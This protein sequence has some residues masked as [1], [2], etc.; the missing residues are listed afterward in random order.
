MTMINGDWVMARVAELAKLS[1]EEG[2]LTR[3]FLSPAHQRGCAQVGDWM[4]AAGMHV[5]QDAIAN[6]IGRYEGHGP[7]AP[8]L[9]IG[10]HIDTVRDAGW[11][12]G[13]LGVILGIAAVRRLHETG[14]H[15]P[16]AIEVIAFGDEENLRFPTSL[17]GSC[18]LAGKLTP[19]ELDAKDVS[20][21]S[22][23]EELMRWGLDP[24]SLADAARPKTD[25]LA[26][27]EVHIEQGPVLDR[28]DLPL[29]IVTAINGATRWRVTLTGMAGHAGTVPMT[30]RQ[31]ALAGFAEI[32]LAVEALG[33]SVPGLV[34]TVGQV[35]ARPGAANVIAGQVLFTIDTRHS[36]DDIRRT[37]LDQLDGLLKDIASRRQLILAVERYYD[38][39][40]APCDRHLQKAWA[41]SLIR[42]GITVHHLASGAG[43]DAMAL[44]G[45][46]PMAMLFVRCDKGISHN[47][48]E[49]ILAA[50]ADLALS[51]LCDFISHFDLAELDRD[52]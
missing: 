31:D 12:D 2:R 4:R 15:F 10:S 34:A 17:L 32:T 9:I 50:D 45:H 20:G 24:N 49:S 5:R 3:L 21:I 14:T 33:N 8:A 40:A 18:A 27:I 6:V 11:Y 16:F 30:M 39:P 52:S 25:A 36:D 42:L 51:V 41:D 37:A 19:G 46:W 22:V 28:A 26:Y 13:N 29:G 44:A 47:P 7:H 23:R 1:D 48:R 35:S 43:H 38:A